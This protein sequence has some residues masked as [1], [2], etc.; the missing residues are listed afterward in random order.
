MMATVLGRSLRLLK[1]DVMNFYEQF[2]KCLKLGSM[3]TPP[4][5]PR[6]LNCRGST[7]PSLGEISLKKYVV[8]LDLTGYLMKILTEWRCSFFPPPLN[9]RSSEI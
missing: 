1:D 4:I 3:R 6:F 5:E 9:A 8:G 2:G 7:R